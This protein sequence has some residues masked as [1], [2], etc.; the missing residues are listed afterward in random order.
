VTPFLRIAKVRVALQ[1]EVGT[2]FISEPNSS[3]TTVGTW[4]SY[5]L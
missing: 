3:I 5:Q 1:V 4:A 2:A